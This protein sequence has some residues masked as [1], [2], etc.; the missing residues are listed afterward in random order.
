MPYHL[1][2]IAIPFVSMMD[3]SDPTYRYM[4]ICGLAAQTLHGERRFSE[5]FPVAELK[6][7]R[8]AKPKGPFSWFSALFS[9]FMSCVQDE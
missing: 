1:T 7:Y 5:A 8:K 6:G 9:V 2:G 4:R 3:S